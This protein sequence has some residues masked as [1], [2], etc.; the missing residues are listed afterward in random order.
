MKLKHIGIA[1][2]IGL[3]ALGAAANSSV[4][5]S[6]A[7]AALGQVKETFAPTGR[8][9][10]FSSEVAVLDRQV[11]SIKGFRVPLEVKTHFLLAAKPSDCPHC[12]EEGPEGYVEVFAVKPV[13]AT[14]GRP[15]TVAG[16]LELR[17]EPSGA[18]YRLLDAVVVSVD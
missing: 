17:N 3:Y 11:V 18:Y 5:P 13:A 6:M 7:W 4:P 15:L 8:T 1:A 14:F 10:Q 9:I 2:G 16:R 12:L